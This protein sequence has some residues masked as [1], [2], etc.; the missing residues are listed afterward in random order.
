MPPSCRE[1]LRRSTKIDHSSVVHRTNRH[2]T[3]PGSVFDHQSFFAE[4]VR[5]VLFSHPGHGT[6]ITRSRF[7]GIPF[8]RNPGHSESR[9][10][11]IPVIERSRD[12]RFC[13]NRLISALRFQSRI[14]HPKPNMKGAGTYFFDN[15]A[16]G[17]PGCLRASKKETRSGS[18]ELRQHPE[19]IHSRKRTIRITANQFTSVWRTVNKTKEAPKNA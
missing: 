9:S 3:P 5:L 2:R 8:H 13:F 6:R 19:S 18:T 1:T 12:D 15:E 17:S 11:G 16:D 4:S 7:I 14:R 10:F